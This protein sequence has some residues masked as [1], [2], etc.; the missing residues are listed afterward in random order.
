M[1]VR[2][3]RAEIPSRSQRHMR[4]FQRTLAERPRVQTGSR[5]AEI[6]VERAVRNHFER[7][8]DALQTT[9]DDAAAGE[10]LLSAFLA[11]RQRFGREAGERSML[12]GRVRA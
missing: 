3:R 6:R 10:Q 8:T 11:H 5:D 2:G 12:G 7:Q 4:L 9:Y 1:R